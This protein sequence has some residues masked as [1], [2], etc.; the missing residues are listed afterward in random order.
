MSY[1]QQERQ[2][3]RSRQGRYSDMNKCQSCAKAVGTNYYSDPR[4]NGG[5]G[6]VLCRACCVAG[7]GLNW[8]DAQAWY[9][10]PKQAQS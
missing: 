2:R 5:I 7:Q 4:S 9:R 10:Q 6:H 8:P 1:G 3:T